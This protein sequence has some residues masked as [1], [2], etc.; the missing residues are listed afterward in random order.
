MTSWSFAH[1]TPWQECIPSL[2]TLGLRG[3]R[4][5]PKPF[6]T[7]ASRPPSQSQMLALRASLGALLAACSGVSWQVGASLPLWAQVLC[8]MGPDGWTWPRDNG[9][10]CKTAWPRL[11]PLP[12]P[13]PLFISYP[14]TGA[15]EVRG[16]GPGEEARQEGQEVSQPSGGGGRSVAW[17]EGPEEGW[18]F[19]LPGGGQARDRDPDS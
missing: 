11:F 13:L 17:A 16:Q 8:Q 6:P 14:R 1:R 12:G 3:S 10:V 4:P 18:C 7:E 15:G 5:G 9:E 19:I 2:P